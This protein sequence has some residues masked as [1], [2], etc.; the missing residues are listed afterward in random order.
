MVYKTVPGTMGM[1][2]ISGHSQSEFAD[3]LAKNSIDSYRAKQV[4]YWIYKKSKLDFSGFTNLPKPVV[5]FLKQNCSILSGEII[6]CVVSKSDSTKKFLIKLDDGN[7]IESV[8][9][10]SDDKRLTACVSTQVGCAVSCVF[11]ASGKTAFKRNLTCSEIISQYLLMR[12]ALPDGN[13]ISNI[14]FMGIGEPLLNFDNLKNAINLFTDPDAGGIGARRITVSTAG[15]AP[16]IE[17]LADYKKQVN[18]SVSLHSAFDKNRNLLV[19]LNK[20]Y[21]IEALLA[22]VKNY[23]SKTKRLVTFEYVLIKGVND[24]EVDAVG[25]GRI[26]K[27]INCKVNLIPYNKI[28]GLDYKAPSSVEVESFRKILIKN[29]INVVRRQRKGFDINSGCGQ[30]KAG[31]LNK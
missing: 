30:L 7:L 25:L 27:N 29:R 8:L 22:A 5:G 3:Y 9:L 28:E 20:K 4:F 12:Q 24:A 16:A 11:C 14:V 1:F 18:L 6:T 15:V 17:K 21:N 19:P 26:L 2:E 13:D 23:I 31:F 10:Q